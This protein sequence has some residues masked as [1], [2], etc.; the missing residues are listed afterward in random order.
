VI[1]DWNGDG[2]DDLGVYRPVGNSFQLRRCA[3]NGP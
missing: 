2:K 3:T 1:G